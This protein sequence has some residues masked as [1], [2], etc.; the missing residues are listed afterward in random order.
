MAF[1][2]LSL[3]PGHGIRE[4]WKSHL[5]TAALQLLR[6]PCKSTWKGIRATPI[7]TNYYC[8][9]PD[10]PGELLQRLFSPF[11]PGSHPPASMNQK[12]P[13]SPAHVTES[14]HRAS[15]H[16][17]QPH[18]TQMARALRAA[19]RR[20]AGASRRRPALPSCRW[21]VRE[22]SYWKWLVPR[23]CCPLVGHGH[24]CC[25]LLGSVGC[26]RAGITEG[27]WQ[28]HFCFVLPSLMSTK[29][30]FAVVPFPAPG[31]L[32]RHVSGR[33]PA[34]WLDSWLT[35]LVS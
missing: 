11:L 26:C 18:E 12:G 30:V 3:E 13:E 14:A 22:N 32:F 2:L 17:A 19:E 4:L 34:S 31:L 20:A 7:I 16:L 15:P 6:R 23:H 27:R 5:K 10:P 9:N 33:Q 25:S 29:R 28:C 35:G 1:G 8:S 21:S 24:Y